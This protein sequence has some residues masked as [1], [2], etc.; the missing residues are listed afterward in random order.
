MIHLDTLRYKS[1]TNKYFQVFGYN[2]FTSYKVLCA[3]ILINC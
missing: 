3:N 1:N 2:H